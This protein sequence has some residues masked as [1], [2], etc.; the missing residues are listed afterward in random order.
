[1]Q[2]PTA[3]AADPAEF[4]HGF[5]RAFE[6][7]DLRGFVAR[8]AVGASAFFPAPEPST[9]HDG[10]TTIEA[11]FAGVFDALRAGAP[12]GPPYHR[13]VPERLEV[14]RL[15]AD[16]AVVSFELR[17]AE[18]L[19]RRTLVLVRDGGSWRIAHLHASN[20]APA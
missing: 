14:A 10:R 7:L 17:N 15:G 2:P 12:S 6:D 4:V 5:L 19:G 1:M 9:R 8:F 16:A 11:R 18:R 13:L 3:E 20:A